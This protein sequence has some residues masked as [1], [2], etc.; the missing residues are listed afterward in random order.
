M[1]PAHTCGGVY[2][3]MTLCCTTGVTRARLPLH[4]AIEGGRR[5]GK[6]GREREMKRI[7]GGRAR[8][9]GKE[10]ERRGEEVREEGREGGREIE[11]TL[12]VTI[13]YTYSSDVKGAYKNVSTF[14]HI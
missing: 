10:R 1:T 2:N 4:T 12:N 5:E 9:G 14:K 3:C 7:K 11:G 6:R 8:D 13:E